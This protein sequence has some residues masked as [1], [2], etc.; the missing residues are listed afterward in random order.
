MVSSETAEL[1]KEIAS[2]NARLDGIESS[3]E[4]LLKELKRLRK[5]DKIM[6]FYELTEKELEEL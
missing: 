6:T 3:M 4:V 1:K 2:V 5:S